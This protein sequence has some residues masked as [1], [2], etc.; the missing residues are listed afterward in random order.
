MKKNILVGGYDTQE[1]LKDA[2]EGAESNG[3]QK[4]NL[5]IVS[6]DGANLESFADNHGVNFRIVGSQELGNQRFLDSV[7]ALFMGEDPATS[8]GMDPDKKRVHGLMNMTW[9]NMQAW[10]LM[11]NMS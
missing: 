8:S 11:G 3:Y 10:Y 4:D 2:I 9:I 7:K 1:D 6:K 5:V